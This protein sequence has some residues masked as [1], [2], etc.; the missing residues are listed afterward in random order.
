[1]PERQNARLLSGQI[2]GAKNRIGTAVQEGPQKLRVLAGVVLEIRVLNNA[3]IAGCV[4]DGGSD[5]GALALVG[6]VPE[7]ADARLGSREALEDRRGPI[8]GMIVNDN[9]FPVHR[10]RQR[11]GDHLRQAAFDHCPLVVNWDQN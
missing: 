5:G 2:A 1:V 7:K 9:Q 8:G 11:R 3:E 10:F 4:P 6:F